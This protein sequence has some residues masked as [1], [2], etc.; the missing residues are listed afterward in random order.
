MILAVTGRK[1]FLQFLFDYLLIS[2]LNITLN[3]YSSISNLPSTTR[4]TLSY[5]N[6]LKLLRD[7]LKRAWAK[8]FTIFYYFDCYPTTITAGKVYEV[9]LIFVTLSSKNYC[10]DF[11]E[12]LKY[13]TIK[14]R[15]GLKTRDITRDIRT[16]YLGIM[17]PLYLW[18]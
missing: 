18:I 17:K 16:K 8:L 6:L 12:N 7:D 5:V 3:G 1:R 9:I 13:Y 14:I 2:D 10:T 15:V 11:N 4:D